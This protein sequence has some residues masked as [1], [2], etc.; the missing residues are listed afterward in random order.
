MPGA[1]RAAAALDEV[2]EPLQVRL[3]PA[4]V[5][6]QHRSGFSTTPSGCQAIC[7]V[8]VVLVSPSRWKVITPAWVVPSEQRRCVFARAYRGRASA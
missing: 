1:G 8:T 4:V 6:P 3:D 5:E 2:L 7:A